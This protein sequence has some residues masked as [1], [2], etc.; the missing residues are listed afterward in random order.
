N[1]VEQKISYFD[2]G[3]EPLNV[4]LMLDTSFSTSD[5]IKDIRKAATAF[6]K[7]LR[8]RD[9]AMIVTFDWQTQKLSE[10]TNNRKVL[11]SAIKEA[12][13]GRYPGTVLNDAEIDNTNHLLQP[14]RCRKKNVILND[15]E[16]REYTQ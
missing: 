15:E 6:L 1:Q 14:T 16:T 10:L 2:T 12:K 3:E 8:P 11:E 9:R 5:V 4:V 7:E 13:D